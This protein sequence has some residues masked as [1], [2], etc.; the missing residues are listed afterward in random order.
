MD[1]LTEINGKFYATAEAYIVTGPTDMP[2][3]MAS[4]FDKTAFNSGYLWV[5]GRYVQANQ[6]NRNGQYWTLDDLQRGE[7]S[8]KYSPI[9]ALHKYLN[10]V[11]TIVETKIISREDASTQRIFPEIQALGAVWAYNFP[12]QAKEIK[13]AH[14]IKQLWW[15]MECIAEARQCLTCEK[16]FPWETAMHQTCEHM[17]ASPIA[18]RR[19]IN[20]TFL[21]GALIYPPDKPGWKDADISEVARQLVAEYAKEQVEDEVQSWEQLMLQFL[22]TADAPH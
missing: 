9:N 12:E 7:A 8:I 18:P 5:A 22:Q 1:L 15:S 17:A 19:F 10:P 2:R 20:P 21:G 4:E 13:A 14:A 6:P 11:G 3:E 16:I